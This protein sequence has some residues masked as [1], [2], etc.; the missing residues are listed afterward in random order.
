MLKWEIPW[1]CYLAFHD[2]S[3]YCDLTKKHKQFVDIQNVVRVLHA[4]YILSA[5]CLLTF[6]LLVSSMSGQFMLEIDDSF[7]Q[8]FSLFKCS[9]FP[10][11]KVQ[12]KE[13]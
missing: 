11:S 3:V 6:I 8:P 7:P 12:L 1:T 5:L 4:L 10:E 2:L 13:S 9:F